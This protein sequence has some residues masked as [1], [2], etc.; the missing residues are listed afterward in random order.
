MINLV[1]IDPSI[2][3]TGL[4]INGEVF[5]IASENIALTKSL[6]LNKWFSLC[7]DYAT[8][9]TVDT[10]YSGIKNYAS[11]EI[12]KLETYQKIANLVRTLVDKHVNPNYNT[13]V[14]IEGYSYSSASGPLIDLVTLSTLIRRNLFSRQNTD[15]VVLAPQSLKKLVGWLTYPAIAKDKKGKKFEYRNKLGTASGAFNKRD[16]Y[17]ALIENTKIITAWVEFLRSQHS[18]IISAKAIPKPIEDIND[19]VAMLH[20][21]ERAMEENNGDYQATLSFLRNY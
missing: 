7:E 1:T 17:T 10:S 16:I 8:I 13:L 2:N 5:S 18:E 11:L 15:L 12:I 20:V 3:S 21:A 6:K 14:L 9:H 19:A 4:T